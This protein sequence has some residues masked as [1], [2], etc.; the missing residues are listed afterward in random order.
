MSEFTTP[1]FPIFMYDGE[2]NYTLTTMGEVIY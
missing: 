2:G 1:E